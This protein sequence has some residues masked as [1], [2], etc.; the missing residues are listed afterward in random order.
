MRLYTITIQTD[1]LRPEEDKL[2]NYTIKQKKKIRD[3]E[4]KDLFS[5]LNNG[6]MTTW[7]E[8]S[9]DPDFLELRNKVNFEF[10]ST[11]SKAYR[12]YIRGDWYTAGKLL[13]EL[14]SIF[15]D[16]GPTKNLHT[17]V[18]IKHNMQAPANWKGYRELTSK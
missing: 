13:Q 4:R 8:I 14:M 10:E 15:P 16:D 17:I 2:L 3:Q 9:S 5:K 7:Q 11:F 6:V 18:N 12:A 1:D